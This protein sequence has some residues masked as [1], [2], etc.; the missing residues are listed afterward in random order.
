MPTYHY[1]A[2]A[3]NGKKVKGNI[4]AESPYVARRQL[5]MRSVHPSSIEEVASVKKE[6]S[7]SLGSL[8]PVNKAGIVDFA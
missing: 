5:R 2:I 4:A 1:T 7:F 6:T 8:G 3:A